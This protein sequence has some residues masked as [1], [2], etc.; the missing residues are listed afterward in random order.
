M[1]AT[2]RSVSIRFAGLAAALALPRWAH[3]ADPIKFGSLL[4]T[5]GNF[6]AY[7]KPM[8]MATDLA[9]DEINRSGG[10]I[11][12]QI[13]K[14]AYD[15]QSNM[16][17][18]TKFA[19]QLARQDKVDVVIGGILSASREAIRPLLNREKILYVYTPLYEGGVCDGNTFLTGT[20]PAQQAEVLVPY[21]VKKW[22]R[23]AYILAADY[24]Y[25]QYMAKWFQKFLAE[26]GA[27]D[28]GLEF[29]PLDVSD[30]NSTIAKIQAAKPDFVI[31]ALVGGAHLSFYRQWAAAGMKGKIPL[32]STTLGVGNEHQ[33]LTA[34]EGDGIL[35][36]YNYSPELQTPANKVF[37]QA[38]GK[39]HGGNTKAINELAVLH[40]QGIKL[41]A[42]GVR[43]AGSLERAK[44]IGAMASGISIDGPS[45]KVS[46]DGPTHHVTL[47][48]HVMEIR[49]QQLKVL[50]SFAQRP[51]R[52]TQ[53]VCNLVKTPASS[54]QFEIKL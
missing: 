29:F 16:A 6:D 13:K 42:E 54:T 31:S 35:V 22:G 12:R 46:I 50:Q 1:K 36:A 49:G 27:A 4:D 11:G 17:M 33:V 40:Y 20:T 2:R 32:V 52:E 21:A 39:M 19:Q 53:A 38:W 34:A 3:A 37:L 5:S 14:S 18:Y 9:I 47:D 24:N 26:S 10:L 51:P 7:G 44:V 15:T 48:V 30:F 45:G 23:K 8:N 43:K 28:V 41:W 25:G